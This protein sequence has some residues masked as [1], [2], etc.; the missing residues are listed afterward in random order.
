V[1]ERGEK[2]RER[3][4]ERGEFKEGAKKVQ[5]KRSEKVTFECELT[6][7]AKSVL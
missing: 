6:R 2:E 4:R 5:A 7:K 1:N 3:E